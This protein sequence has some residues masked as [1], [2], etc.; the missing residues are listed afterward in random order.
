MST[1]PVTVRSV[2]D[3]WRQT[4]IQWMFVVRELAANISALVGIPISVEYAAPERH[5]IA[6]AFGYGPHFF[7]LRGEAGNPRMN[8]LGQILGKRTVLLLALDDPRESPNQWVNT[9]V[10]RFVRTEMREPLL[11]ASLAHLKKSISVEPDHYRRQF[12]F[13]S[14]FGCIY[15]CSKETKA[16]RD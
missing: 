16:L 8:R 6:D 11:A 12:G 14:N 9:A 15:L 5:H 7:A 3:E 2:D 1:F 13:G 4:K 10:S